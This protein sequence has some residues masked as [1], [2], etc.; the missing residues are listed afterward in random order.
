M[1]QSK[2]SKQK[3]KTTSDKNPRQTASAHKPKPQVVKTAK[4]T[5]SI[6]VWVWTLVVIVVAA[7]GYWLIRITN[8]RQEVA[9]TLPAEISV[10]EAAKLDPQEWFLL[11]VRE[12]DEWNQEHIEWA[13]LIPLGQLNDRL[14]ELPEDQKIVVVCRSGNRSAEGRDILLKAGFKAVTS[15]AGGMNDWINQGNLVVAGP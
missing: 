1:A 15:M 11:D 2:K 3:K 8:Q 14:D 12:Q 7:G 6:P 4:S 5:G 9:N 13:T 10:A